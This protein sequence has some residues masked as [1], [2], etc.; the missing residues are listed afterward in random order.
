MTRAT[1]N[2]RLVIDTP[3]GRQHVVLELST[4][5]GRLRGTARDDKHGQEVPLTDLTLD[6]D[7]LT[8]AQAIRKPLRL[9][10]TF[11]VTIAGDELTGHARAGRLPASKVSGHRTS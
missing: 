11:D 8:W 7:Q 10:L 3:I 4:V 1:G 2:W 5:D 9:N 6:G